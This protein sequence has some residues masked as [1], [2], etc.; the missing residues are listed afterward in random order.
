[1]KIY[2]ESP[3][4]STEMKGLCRIKEDNDMLAVKPDLIR[5]LGEGDD[6]ELCF[7]RLEP[8]ARE[9]IDAETLKVLICSQLDANGLFPDL[10]PSAMMLRDHPG[11]NALCNANSLVKGGSTVHLCGNKG[12]DP[13]P[14]RVGTIVHYSD[15]LFFE[16]PPG[17]SAEPWLC[18]MLGVEQGSHALSKRNNGDL[19]FTP[20]VV[21]LP[22]PNPVP[23]APPSRFPCLDAP[24]SRF[25]S[26]NA[27]AAQEEP[28]LYDNDDD[29][30][31]P[32]QG[33]VTS[34]W[35]GGDDDDDDE[36]EHPKPTWRVTNEDE[37]PTSFLRVT[38][39]DEEPKPLLRATYEELYGSSS[40]PILADTEQGE[41]PTKRARLDHALLFMPDGSQEH[42]PLP[43]GGQDAT[44]LL[45]QLCSE[46][47]WDVTRHKILEHALP[48][49][50]MWVYSGFSYDI[51]YRIDQD[52]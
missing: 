30:E 4:H 46:R 26:L 6:T 49:L 13:S 37:E 27:A 14:G 20:V 21:A 52:A 29:D 44:L 2:N 38:Y 43:R 18:E 8:E 45:R 19:W 10:A 1:M 47:G 40:F 12:R 24:P 17:E 41:T 22:W 11:R 39:E 35:V 16:V 15:D 25:P 9:G 5:V 51:K 33:R 36:E 23:N 7:I 34:I 3:S 42:Y 50:A 48:L 31:W 32:G 28:I